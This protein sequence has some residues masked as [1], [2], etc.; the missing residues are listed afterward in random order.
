MRTLI[1]LLLVSN[2]AYSQN[3]LPVKDGKVVYEVV[4]TAQ[5]NTK[6]LHALAKLWFVDAFKDAK[7]VIQL[8]EEA[9]IIGKGLFRFSQGATPYKVRF[10]VRIDLK[11]GKYRA[12][13][14]DIII[15]G[16]TAEIEYSA[17]FYNEKKSY[18][19]IK[20]NLDEGMRQMIADLTKAMNKKADTDF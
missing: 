16:G 8:D 6:E 15:L 20:K 13:F 1:L 19:K 4:D 7:E 18:A 2:L 3:E 9:L 14:Y 11:D 10:S 5:G 12:Q 17:E